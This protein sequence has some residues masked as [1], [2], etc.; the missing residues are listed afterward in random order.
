MILPLGE[1]P[2]GKDYA[3][4]EHPDPKPTMDV[5]RGA[6]DLILVDL[7]RPVKRSRIDL[8]LSEGAGRWL[9]AVILVQNVRGT[10]ETEIAE[11]WGRLHAAGI[12]DVA[13]VENF[14]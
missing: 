9:D 2:A 3:I 4:D 10:P 7:G 6:Y 5:L 12:A 13:L 11:S 8:G 1:P 14:V